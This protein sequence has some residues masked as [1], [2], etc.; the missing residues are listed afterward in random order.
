MKKF[1]QFKSEQQYVAEVGPYASA[2]MAAAGLVGLGTA[3][4]RLFKKTKEKNTKFLKFVL[5]I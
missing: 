2:F 5:Y 4:F 1:K 3:G